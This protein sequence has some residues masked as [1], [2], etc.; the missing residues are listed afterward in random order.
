M[1]KREKSTE[2]EGQLG[3]RARGIVFTV[4]MLGMALASATSTAM[5]NMLP[6]VMTDFDTDASV[7]QWLVSGYTL[8]SAVAIPAAAFLIRRLS[9]RRLFLLAMALYCVGSAVCA[10]AS[11]FQLLLAGRVLQGCASGI[12]ISSVQ[13]IILALYPVERHGTV[14]GI[15]SLG[16]MATP[17]VT[18][19]IVG[20]VLSMASWR[21]VFA[22]LAAAGAAVVLAAIAFLR[23]AKQGANAHFDMFSWL[24]VSSGVCGVIIGVGNLNASAPF[25]LNVLAFLMAGVVCTVV[26]CLRQLRLPVPLVDLRVFRHRRFGVGAVLT[27]LMYIPIMGSATI[28]PLL[29]QDMMGHSALD[30]ALATL[31]SSVMTPIVSLA[32]GKL[33]DRFG[34]RGVVC[35]GFAIMVASCLFLC[36]IDEEVSLLDVAPAYTLLSVGGGCCMSTVRAFALSGLPADDMV[37]ASAIVNLL[38][39]AASASAPMLC[40]LV[41]TWVAGRSTLSG[42][43]ASIQGA[44]GA[45]AFMGVLSAACL[46]LALARVWARR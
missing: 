41:M 44:A 46:V 23:N 14:L 39:Q 29:V 8:A 37:S 10:A 25:E 4:L 5:N 17:V 6:T 15:Y 28:A 1:K 36:A 9:T 27:V 42:G 35:I 40:V 2:S 32:A 38:N 21:A 31:T 43:S 33:Y 13:V 20:R 12:L 18:P 22:G 3:D 7:A 30:Y 26:F 45:F 24:L 16:C 34:P 11:S 19:T